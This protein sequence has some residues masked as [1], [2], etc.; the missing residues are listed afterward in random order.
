MRF[1]IIALLAADGG[2]GGVALVVVVDGLGGKTGL[3]TW[4]GFGGSG[5][6]ILL[7]EE[8]AVGEWY[9]IIFSMWSIHECNID[10]NAA[11]FWGFETIAINKFRLVSNLNQACVQEESTQ[12]ILTAM[13]KFYVK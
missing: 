6:A 5:G 10:N 13:Y 7:V 11:E 9:S 3:L 2:I 12:T 1:I 4:D 8:E